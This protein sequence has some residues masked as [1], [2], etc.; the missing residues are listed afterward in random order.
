METNNLSDYSEQELTKMIYSPTGSYS[1]EMIEKARIE[2]NKRRSAPE[3]T[4]KTKNNNN[5][6][7][8]IPQMNM[9]HIEQ[10]YP[11]LRFVSAV[12]FV[13]AWVILILFVF[14][15]IGLFISGEQ[16][17]MYGEGL[18][19]GLGIGM[20]FY[21]IIAFFILLAISLSIRVLIDIEQNT[22]I[23]SMK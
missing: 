20:L 9:Q 7:N 15:S 18:G 17:G 4:N 11:V 19:L 23:T 21:G 16:L 10:K 12:F 14:I 22:R 3:T 6:N 2:L 5:F 1:Q 8:S 13:L